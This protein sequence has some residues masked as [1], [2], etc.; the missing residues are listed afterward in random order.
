MYKFSSQLWNGRAFVLVIRYALITSPLT[1]MRTER[2]T[3]RHA[4][5]VFWSRRPAARQEI[6]LDRA[7]IVDT[8]G[9]TGAGF[10]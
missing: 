2:F 1:L 3:G 7:L 6:F 5:D 10:F 8:V 4:M 9:L